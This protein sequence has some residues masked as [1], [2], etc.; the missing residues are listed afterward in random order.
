MASIKELDKKYVTGTYNRFPVL[1]THGKNDLCWDENGKEYI[2]MESGYGTNSFGFCDEE[3]LA[4]VTAQLQ[5]VQHTSNLYYT[6]PCVRLAA[7][8]A[9]KT[10]M[11]NMFFANS[12]G[13]S[14]ECALKAAR[15]YQK[16]HK[17]PE[18]V[19]II[20]M[21]NSFHGRSYGALTA[22]CNP[23]YH[24][25]FE[26]LVPGFKYAKFN[27]I[28]SVKA[29]VNPVKTAAILV[30]CVQGEGGVNVMT[31]EF[32]DRLA[33]ICQEND[34]LL[35]CDEV[36]A[37]NARTGKLYAYEHFG[38]KPDIVTTAKGV[39]GG[40]PIGLCM[41][42]EKTKNALVPGTHG[43]TFGGNPVACAGAISLVER[44]DQDFLDSVNRKSRMVFDALEGK[45]GI[46]S[47]EGL[48]LM[49]AFTPSKKKASDIV[50]ECID[51]GVLCITAGP[52]G[53][54]VR[55]LPPLTITEEHL[56]KALEVIAAVAA[57]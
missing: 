27:D 44:M 33:Q 5:K 13:E 35:I 11:A 6:E 28:E 47:V 1:I 14:N 36:Q 23:H 51:Q 32:A 31:Q 55:L 56:A 45:E 12:G 57:E 17:G 53:E 29:A 16:L 30:E 43:T 50:N 25:G 9:E 52:N 21:E 46:A 4:A 37:G 48:G 10:G 18:C 38:L 7:L 8:L 54:K 49:I 19:E 2:D 24:E 40:L 26:P 42:S 15:R 3:W 34:V 39:G 20:S 22:T 41:F